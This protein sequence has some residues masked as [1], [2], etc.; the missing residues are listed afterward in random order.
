M[1]IMGREVSETME[2]VFVLLIVFISLAA[3]YL[4][5]RWIGE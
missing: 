5:Q 1:P 4:I 2:L 3:M